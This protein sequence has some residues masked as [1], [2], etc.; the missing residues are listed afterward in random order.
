MNT[1]EKALCKTVVLSSLRD[2]F[3]VICVLCYD[4]IFIRKL[5]TL[6]VYLWN[7]EPIFFGRTGH[8][9]S[10]KSIFW[11]RHPFGKVK[12][13]MESFSFK[14]YETENIFR[15]RYPDRK[16]CHLKKSWAWWSESIGTPWK[17]AFFCCIRGTYAPINQPNIS[18]CS[19]RQQALVWSN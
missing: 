1:D 9:R 2:C 8:P 12:T 14:Y 18:N 19:S 3:V 11:R 16:L 10:Q 13:P 17:N 15:F 7:R 6:S 5:L 4:I